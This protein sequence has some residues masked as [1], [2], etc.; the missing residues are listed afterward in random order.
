M[1]ILQHLQCALIMMY[2]VYDAF[3]DINT[4]AHLRHAVMDMSVDESYLLPTKGNDICLH[5][6]KNVAASLKTPSD[7]ED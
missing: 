2:S 7:L 1:Q 3:S 5:A 4:V 6:A